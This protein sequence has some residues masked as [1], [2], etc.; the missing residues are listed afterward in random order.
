MNALER[1]GEPEEVAQAV[2]FLASDESSYM[3]GGE[4]TLDGGMT[5]GGEIR[6]IAKEL[7]IYRDE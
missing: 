4:I 3:T 6:L 2:I 1:A 5:A 7:G